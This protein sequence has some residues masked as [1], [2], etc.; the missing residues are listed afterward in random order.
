VE[1]RIKNNV[2][3]LPHVPL[4]S[5]VDSRSDSHLL[6]SW[7]HAFTHWIFFPPSLGACSQAT[8]YPDYP[9]TQ[10]TSLNSSF[11]IG[12]KILG[13]KMYSKISQWYHL[14]IIKKYSR[15][16]TVYYICKKVRNNGPIINYELNF[17]CKKLL[18][19]F[20]AFSC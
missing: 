15:Y 19:R 17:S 2:Y 7:N 6:C 18:L 1:R 14:I 12:N 8:N 9:I 5:L 3:R 16:Y 11:K 4:T 20:K 10:L 13:K